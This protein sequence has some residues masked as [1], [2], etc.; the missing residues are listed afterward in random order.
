[1]IIRAIGS[2]FG[3]CAP[4]NNFEENIMNK[5]NATF[6]LIFSAALT[7]SAVRTAVEATQT[8]DTRDYILTVTSPYG[9]V[10]YPAGGVSTNSWRSIAYSR[11]EGY[12]VYEPSETVLHAPSSFS[13]EGIFPSTGNGDSAYVTLTNVNSTL[14]W[15]WSDWYWVTW[16]WYGQGEIQPV[17]EDY[18]GGNGAWCMEQVAYLFR[19]V[20]EYGWLFTGWSD[21]ASGGPSATNLYFTATEPTTLTASFSDDPDGDGL[22]NTNE[23]AVGANPWMADTDGDSFNDGFEFNNGLSPTV[24]SS[25]FVTHILDNAETYGL[26]P[27]NVVLDVAVGQVALDIQGTT[28]RLRLQMEQSDDLQSW[29]NA[30]EAVEWTMPVDNG[31]K[32]LRVRSAAGE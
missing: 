22:K 12:P 20:P 3:L 27:S 17:R 21:G 23:W 5:T 11:V 18:L 9:E 16:G 1:M 19:A 14:T 4:E 29:T 2:V 28:A 6:L 7:A 13:G 15:V 32:F 10:A 25:P 30:G 31:K 24:D 8:I 26:Y